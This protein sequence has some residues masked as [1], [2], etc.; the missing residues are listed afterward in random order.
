MAPCWASA[1]EP[2]R[3]PARLVELGVLRAALDVVVRGM[4]TIFIFAFFTDSFSSSEITSGAACD[5][6]FCGGVVDVTAGG[7]TSG[8]IRSQPAGAEAY[9]PYSRCSANC[10]D[11]SNT[12]GEQV[13]NPNCNT[14]TVQGAR[15]GAQ[16]HSERRR[17]LLGG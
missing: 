6:P 8:I 1:S 12:D 11:A 13:H 5:R 15:R 17:L 10:D 3:R 7:R 9:A 16:A 2:D 4:G 14:A